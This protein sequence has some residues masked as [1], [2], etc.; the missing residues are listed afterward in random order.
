MGLVIIIPKV[1]FADANLGKVTLSGDIPITGLSINLEDSYVGTTVALVA[2]FFP[3]TTTQRN[4]IWSIESGDEY[5]SVTGS[6]LTIKPN[7][8]RNNVAIK[9]TSVSNP[10][11]SAT[12]TISLTYYEEGGIANPQLHFPFTS[13]G[14]D[15]ITGLAPTTSSGVTFSNDGALFDGTVNGSMCQYTLI[16]NY[17]SVLLSFKNIEQDGM[18][19][20]R[21]LYLFNTKP[22][23]AGTLSVYWDKSMSKLGTEIRSTQSTPSDDKDIESNFRTGQ[24]NKVAVVRSDSGTKIYVN[25]VLA[26][27][28]E[29]VTTGWET[30][31]LTIGNISGG[32]R[33]FNGYIKD[34]YMFN[35]ELT[36]SEAVEYTTL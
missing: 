28:S 19:S 8:S 24:W 36:D 15:V 9:C 6:T 32:N 34:F 31:Y 4:V 17:K 3:A 12:K 10:S 13:N 5:A 1:S 2:S 23:L 35:R 7:A 30:K 20:P 14:A 25:G 21:Y 26:Y 33:S 27:S 29:I 22:Q 18:A 11:I 16:N